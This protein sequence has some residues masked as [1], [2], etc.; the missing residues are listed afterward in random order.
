MRRYVAKQMNIYRNVDRRVSGA[1]RVGHVLYSQRA[2]PIRQ[3][4]KTVPE[5]LREEET[6]S[7]E[8]AGPGLRLTQA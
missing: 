2:Q 7:V 8:L 4:V 1:T 5:A 3:R 6:N